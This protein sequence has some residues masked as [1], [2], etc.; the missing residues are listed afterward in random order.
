MDFT[1]NMMQMQQVINNLNGV[2]GHINQVE[3]GLIALSTQLHEVR[4]VQKMLA[5]MLVTKNI[6][7]EEEMQVAFRDNVSLPMQQHVNYI[8]NQ[9]RRAENEAKVAVDT[10][11]LADSMKVE[12]EPEE[13]ETLDTSNIVLASERFKK[14]SDSSEPS[15]SD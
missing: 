8:N 3:N 12:D 13:E 6:V 15:N 2:M 11:A 5:D 9:I 7:T 14:G 1:A 4:L 10:T